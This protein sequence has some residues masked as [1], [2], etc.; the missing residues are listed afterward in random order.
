M[1]LQASLT[2]L[3]NEYIHLVWASLIPGACGVLKQMEELESWVWFSNQR[4]LENARSHNSWDLSS[5]SF[6]GSRKMAGN[7]AQSKTAAGRE[8]TP[9]IQDSSEEKPR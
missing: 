3:C 7:F 2:D 5:R 6:Q 9:T 1:V 8:A 4:G